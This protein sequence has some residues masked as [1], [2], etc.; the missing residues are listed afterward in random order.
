[1]LS[2]KKTWTALMG[3]LALAACAS[4]GSSTTP[5]NDAAA[6]SSVA[7]PST[8]ER[9]AYAPVLIRG[10]TVFDGDGNEFANTDVT[11]ENGRITGVGQNLAAPAG[12][13]IVDGRGKFVTPGII[14]AHSHLGDYPSPGI[15]ANSDGNEVTQPNTAEVWAEHSVWPQDPGFQRAVAGGIT[16]LHIL[17]GS[18]NL[19]GGRGTTLRPVLGVAT[20]QQMK[21][22]NAPQSLKMAC[23]ENPSRVYGARNQSPATDMGNVAGWRQAFARATEYNR[24]LERSRAGGA[25]APRAPDRDLELDTLAGVLRGEIRVQWHC[26]RANEM[27]IGLDIAEEFGFQV[28]AFHHAVE[29]YKIADLL[30]EHGTCAA[31]WADWW[32]FKMEAY[33]GI[34]ENIPFVDAPDNSCAIVHSDSAVGIQR[35]NQEA[36]KA[37]SDGRRAGLEI[38]RAH[39]W[40]W[41]SRNPARAL[42]IENETGTLSVGKAADVVVWS[43]DP[44]SSYAVAERVYMDG[45]LAHERGASRLPPSDFELGQTAWSTGQ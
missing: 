1:M 8:Y 40:T 37:M 33:D 43:A 10:A 36:A 35:L 17:P 42:G 13:E 32:G 31:M 15:Q 5:S 4:T 11:F 16:A 44:L 7:F 19:F 12:A 38:S 41:L 39:A 18:A 9:R 23:G 14:D 2:G 6:T 3:G 45:A 27:A 22:P 21:F 20:M 25:N 26:Y 24:N 34:R 30:A 28:A 29:A